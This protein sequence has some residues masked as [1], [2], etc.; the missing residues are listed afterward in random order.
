MNITCKDN[1][2]VPVKHTQRQATPDSSPYVAGITNAALSRPKPQIT[3]N[4]TIST[5]CRGSPPLRSTISVSA[6]PPSPLR[7][8]LHPERWQHYLLLAALWPPSCPPHR[9]APPLSLWL[10]PRLVGPRELLLEPIS[11]ES[12][13]WRREGTREGFKAG[14]LEQP[15]ST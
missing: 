1:Q 3:P 6:S 13:E 4:Q 8:P 11:C 14:I 15:R 5:P 12:V 9:Q 10:P 2:Y 7:R